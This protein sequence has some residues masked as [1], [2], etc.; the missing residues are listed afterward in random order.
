M[1]EMI[2]PRPRVLKT[3]INKVTQ[4]V[5]KRIA[6]FG[7][8]VFISYSNKS[9]S[10]YLEIEFSENNRVIV[11]ISDHPADKT[12]WKFKFDIHVL[13]NRRGSIDYIEFLNSFRQIA[14]A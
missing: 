4:H 3:N 11:R 7:Y 13:N 10:R 12:N 8:N 14:G 2:E 1:K 6:E 5:A 9:E